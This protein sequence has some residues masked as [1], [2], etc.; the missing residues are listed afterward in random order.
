VDNKVFG[1]MAHT[2]LICSSAQRWF[3]K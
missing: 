2:E 3:L 1:G